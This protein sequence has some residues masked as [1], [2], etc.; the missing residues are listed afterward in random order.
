MNT[1][2]NRNPK[3]NSLKDKI[4]SQ[5]GSWKAQINKISTIFDLEHNVR[6]ILHFDLQINFILCQIFSHAFTV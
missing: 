5:K 2:N 3:I 6:K 1:F 4:P